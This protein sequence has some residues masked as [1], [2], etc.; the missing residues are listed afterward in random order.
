MEW[1][2]SVN[3]PTLTWM[4]S[5]P[6]HKR[7]Q[8][9]WGV[10]VTHFLTSFRIYLTYLDALLYLKHLNLLYFILVLHSTPDRSLTVRSVLNERLIVVHT[11]AFAH[12][13]QRRF[14]CA[15]SIW[16]IHLTISQRRGACSSLWCV[17]L[18]IWGWIIIDNSCMFHQYISGAYCLIPL[19]F[20]LT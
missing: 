7:Q 6:I 13:W 5:Q 11:S 15:A 18:S 2:P 10:L 16:N 1:Y 9:A 20:T 3:I 14:Q 8:A 4:G 12:H 19:F 17:S